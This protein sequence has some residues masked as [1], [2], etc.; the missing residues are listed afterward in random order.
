MKYVKLGD[1]GID[2]SM[3]SLG[4]W[5]FAGDSFWGPQDDSDSIATVSAA[6]DAGVNFMDTAEGYGYGR[7]EEVLGKA[8]KG[9]RDKAVIATKINA[10]WDPVAPHM[11]REGVFFAAEQSLKRLQS[12]YIDLYYIH[13][14]SDDRP[15]EETLDAMMELKKQGKIR[16][17]GIC[18]FGLKNLDKLSAYT[19]QNFVVVHQ[20]PYSLL[21]RA[22]EDGIKEETLKQNMGIV[23]YSP[24][25]QG[26]LTGLYTDLETTPDYIKVTRFFHH[27]RSKASGHGENG[28]E[29]ALYT[30]ISE[31]KAIAKDLG[32][33]MPEMAL[34]WLLSR[35]GIVSLLAGSRKPAEIIQNAAAAEVKLGDDVLTKLTSI[36]Q[37]VRNV[38]GDNPDMWVGREKTRFR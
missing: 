21:W 18:N 16:A 33:S 9:K 7:S 29:E 19:E 31:L 12:D 10:D 20:L 8:L 23:C 15:L 38:L 24:L 27:S 1:T 5:P 22:I 35:K 11:S 28:C 37:K 2:V 36:T 32:L 30:A 25:S 4:C 3:I 13:W 14:P 17:A 6:L 26:L 34:G